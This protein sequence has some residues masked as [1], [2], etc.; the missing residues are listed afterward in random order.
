MAACCCSLAGWLTGWWVL[1]NNHGCCSGSFGSYQNNAAQYCY[2]VLGFEVGFQVGFGSVVVLLNSS[3]H[4]GC[5][6]QC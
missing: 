3:V 2:S 1:P 4:L 5:V 6:V